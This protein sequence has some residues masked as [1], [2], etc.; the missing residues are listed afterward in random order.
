MHLKEVTLW[1]DF[2]TFCRM[3]SNANRLPYKKSLNF[4]GT[5][6]RI[7]IKKR[8]LRPIKIYLKVHNSII[9]KNWGT[10]VNKIYTKFVVHLRLKIVNCSSVLFRSLQKFL[11]VKGLSIC[12]VV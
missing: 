8:F 5:N 2:L 9:A 10:Y 12:R 11:R 3:M 6:S 1:S 4:Q 7:C